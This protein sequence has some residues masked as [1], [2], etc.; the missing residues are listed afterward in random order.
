MQINACLEDIYTSAWQYIKDIRNQ[1]PNLSTPHFVSAFPDYDMAERRVV[2][3]AQETKGWLCD[4]ELV[5]KD[6]LSCVTRLMNHYAQ[7]NLGAN[8]K[9]RATYWNPVHDLY[10]LSLPNG[11]ECGFVS[12]NALIMDEDASRP[13]PTN[14]EKIK[15]LFLLQKQILALKPD[16]VIF[17]TGPDYDDVLKNDF[18][19]IQFDGDNWYSICK[20][21]FL[22]QI[23][24]RTYHPGYLKRQKRLEETQLKIARAVANSLTVF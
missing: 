16:I 8:Y 15:Q 2:F 7:F 22:P 1:S 19:D 9:Y 24:I 3:V 12:I 6:T 21:A 4:S 5:G 14:I 23:S 17:H 10:K 13:T 11:P 20:S 18:P